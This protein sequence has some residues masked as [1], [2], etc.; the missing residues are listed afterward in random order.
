MD[1]Q[2]QRPMAATK[3]LAAE[4]KERGGLTNEVEELEPYWL[5][6]DKIRYWTEERRGGLKWVFVHHTAI[7]R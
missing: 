4:G 7:S 1:H 3:R 5:G 2:N 6:Q